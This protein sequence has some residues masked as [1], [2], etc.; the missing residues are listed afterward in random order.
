MLEIAKNGLLDPTSPGALIRV[1]RD[2]SHTEVI[3]DGLV[4]PGGVAID[5]RDRIFITN[6]STEAGTGEVDQV[7]NG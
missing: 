4:A 1:N 3:S 6:H 2:G 5:G 7:V